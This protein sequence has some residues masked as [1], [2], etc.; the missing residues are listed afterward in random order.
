MT[1]LGQSLTNAPLFDTCLFRQ[2]MTFEVTVTSTKH[3]V[4]GLE[5]HGN[6]QL[7]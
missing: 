3:D 2:A 7:L 5:N 6:G 1:T 4:F